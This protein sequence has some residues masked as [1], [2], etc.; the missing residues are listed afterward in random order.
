MDTLDADTEALSARLRPGG[1]T[2][3][4]RDLL[5]AHGGPA[6]VR[7]LPRARW[8]AAGLD[9]P[10]IRAL[11]GEPGALDADVL[12]RCRAWLRQPGHRLVGWHDPDYPPL[13]RR[14]GSPPLALFVDG[15]P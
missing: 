15:D 5:D 10:Q 3:P 6:A 4:R 2:A 12:A 11:E 7:A 14:A 1:A 9:T 13:L 8:R